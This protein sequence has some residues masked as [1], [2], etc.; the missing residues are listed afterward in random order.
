[1][2]YNKLSPEEEGVIIKKGTEAPFTGKY[3]K[4]FEDGVYLCRRCNAPLYESK[5][6][7]D[8]HCGW[9]SF[10]EEISGA[11][12]KKPDKDGVRTEIICSNCG[13]HLGHIF[14]GENYTPKNIRQCVNSVSMQFVPD[15]FKGEEHSIVLGG[16]CFWCL[17]AAFKELKGIAK[18]IPGYA[19]GF[20]SNPAYEDVSRGD[21][22][23][24]EVV[25]IIYNRKII[26]FRDILEVF[27]SIHD[28]TT[29]NRQGNDVGSQYR[30]LILYQTWKQKEELEKIIKELLKA[31]DNPIVTESKPLDIFYPA[32]EHHKDYY[33]KHPKESYCQIVIAPKIDKL[34]N[35]YKELLK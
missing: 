6:K 20:K 4:F 13:A 27:F 32:E 28:P 1:M 16:G 12:A 29:P 15:D 31:Y 21:T 10:D 19:G 7:F 8:A 22:G 5:N 9:P 18:V 34:R 25:K 35:K 24:A 26:S 17:E 33:E 11:I 23:H 30:S 14:T 3:D 2:E